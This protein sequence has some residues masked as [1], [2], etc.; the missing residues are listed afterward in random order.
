MSA[1]VGGSGGLV[2][3]PIGPW[4]VGPLKIWQ[5]RPHLCKKGPHFRSIRPSDDQLQMINVMD[6]I[7]TE[8]VY[9]VNACGCKKDWVKIKKEQLVGY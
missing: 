2:H 1:I 3:R 7:E 5:K 6:R 4:P 8:V 9:S